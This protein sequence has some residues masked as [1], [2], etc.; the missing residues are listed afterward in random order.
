MKAYDEV[1][2]L[3]KRSAMTIEHQDDL[4]VRST[5]GIL[6]IVFVSSYEQDGNNKVKE[7]IINTVVI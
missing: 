2:I 1:E 4:K 7:F 3:R 5:N 6:S